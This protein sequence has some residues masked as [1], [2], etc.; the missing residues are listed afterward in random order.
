MSID[1]FAYV[2]ATVSQWRGRSILLKGHGRGAATG[3]ASCSAREQGEKKG[4]IF[5]LENDGPIPD[6]LAGWPRG[7]GYPGVAP[8]AGVALAER[9]GRP[10]LLLLPPPPG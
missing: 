5:I 4:Y 1:T 7:T 9:A 8:A 6:P 10:F 2:T 3:G